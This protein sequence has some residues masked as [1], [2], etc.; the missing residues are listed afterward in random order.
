MPDIGGG[1]GNALVQFDNLEMRQR[2]PDRIAPLQ[3]FASHYFRPDDA[4]DAVPGVSRQL[5]R[6]LR[7]KLEPV[8]HDVGI[9]KR[10]RH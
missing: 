3:T 4:T 9:E 5:C 1:I 7:A 10:E 8:D 6:R 2:L